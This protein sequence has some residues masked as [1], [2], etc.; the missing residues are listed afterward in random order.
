MANFGELWWGSDTLVV[1]CAGLLGRD[2]AEE[3][4]EERRGGTGLEE[5][6]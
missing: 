6:G 5:E 1:R 2:G 3:E 4:E